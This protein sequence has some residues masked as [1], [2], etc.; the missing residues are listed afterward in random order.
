LVTRQ[1]PTELERVAESMQQHALDFLLVTSPPNV[2]YVGGFEAA[3][4]TGFVADITGWLPAVALVA[5]DGAGSLIVNDTE[6]ANAGGSWFTE[7]RTFEILGHTEPADPERSFTDALAA[8]LSAAGVAGA[9]AVVGVES[10]LPRIAGELLADACPDAEMRDAGDALAAARR[11]KTAREVELLKAAV[12]VADEGQRRLLELSA[13]GERVDDVGL[14]ADAVRAM[15]RAAGRLLPVSGA[16]VTGAATADWTTPG[17]VGREVA[18]GEPVL[19]DI[20]PRMGGY[21]ADCA[22]TVIVGAEPTREQQRFLA[23][24]REACLA[25]IELLRPGRRCAEAWQAVRDTLE[26][27]G[28][29]MSHYAGHQIGTAVNEPPRLLP[30]DQTVIEP[31]MV[32]AVEAGAYEGPAGTMGA[33]AEKV[34]LVTESGPEILSGFDWCA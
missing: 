21:W 3:I 33:R 28:I 9:H 15:E 27:H 20:G 12:A 14:W 32:F 17:P 24:S 8:A 1:L 29:P 22:N 18:S 34:A 5:A 16:V 23:A 6:V 7:V 31:G 26:R 4:P 2:T 19:L 25:G 10:T 13:S 30:Y 11:T